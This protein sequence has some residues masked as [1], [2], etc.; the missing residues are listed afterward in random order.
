MNTFFNTLREYGLEKDETALDHCSKPVIVDLTPEM[1]R[2]M[3][4]DSISRLKMLIE[5][6]E[7]ETGH[8]DSLESLQCLKNL[9]A[10]FEGA[11]KNLKGL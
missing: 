1:R 11:I 3:L 8:K 6:E 4:N 2:A 5:Q 7:I 9:V 10:V